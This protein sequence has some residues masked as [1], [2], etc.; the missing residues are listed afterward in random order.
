MSLSNG[1]GGRELNVAA[2][3]TASCSHEPERA[4]VL[5]HGKPPGFPTPSPFKSGR[6]KPKRDDL[7]GSSRFASARAAG[8][9][10]VISAVHVIHPFGMAWTISSPCFLWRLGAPVSSLYGALRQ[11]VEVPT[12]FAC[13]FGFSLHRY[14]GV[15]ISEFLPRAAYSTGQRFNQLSYART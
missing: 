13:P 4:R 10:P 9:E 8:F 14:P 2:R 12:V 3:Y 5:R 7:P 15:F 11:F 1:A 6:L